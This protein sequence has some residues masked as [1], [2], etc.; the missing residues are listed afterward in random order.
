MKQN[1][2][3]AAAGMALLLG[4]CLTACTPT[5]EEAA[6]SSQPEPETAGTVYL[7]G[8]EHANEEMIAQELELWEELYAAGARDLFLE[9]G[10]ASAQLLNRWMQAE[11]DTLLNEHFKA[12][13]GTYGGSEYYQ[14]FYE[15]IKQNCP[16]TVFHGTDI[17]HQYR[18]LG[19]QYLT[20]LAAEGKKDSPEY[21]QVL[22]S[23]QQA[24]QYYSYSYA[25]KEA[26]ADAYRENCMAENFMRELEALDAEKKTDVMGIYGAVHTALDGMNYEDG[27][28]PCMANQLHQKYGERIVSKDLRSGSKDLPEETTPVMGEKT[29]T[30]AGKTYTAIYLGEEDIAAWAGKAVGRRFWRVEDAYADFTAQPKTNDVLPCNNYP[31]PVQEGQ[32]FALEYILKDGTTQWKYYAADGTVWQEMPST[33]EYAVEPSEDSQGREKE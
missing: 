23:I 29:L 1:F 19:Y 9:D 17:E 22:E 21:A 3:L 28:V 11:D 33:R 26:E 15:K 12:V 16:E 4:L 24:K 2:W 32:A 14:A 30:V 8:E 13:Q 18:S 20:Y 25:G 5:T 27:T 6:A 31:V 10:Y 7:Y